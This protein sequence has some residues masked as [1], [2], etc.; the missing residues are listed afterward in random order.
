MTES[1]PSAARDQT[2]LRRVNELSVLAV[3]R[4]GES[5]PLREVA[6]ATGLS[7]RTT[8][9]VA[10]A[11]EAHGWLASTETD[12][13]NRRSVGRPARHYRFRPGV[14]HVVGIDVGTRRVQ[15]QVADLA[16][17]TV[18][19]SHEAVSPRDSAT[20]RLAAAERAL[21][22]ALQSA[23]LDPADIW[24][25]VMGTSG[26]V[27]PDGTVTAST[28]LPGWSGLH[29][30]ERLGAVL[31][32]R[33]EVAN[34]SNLAAL[35]ERWL[36]HRA[37]TMLYLM[38]G[39]RLGAGLVI[40]GQL[41][42]GSTG[43]AGEIGALRGVGWHD[44]ADRLI[45]HGDGD[46]AADPATAA[47]QVFQKARNGD[48]AAL[49]AVDRFVADIA[50]GA[51][52]MVLTLDPDLVVLGGGFAGAADLLLPRLADELARSCLHP[53]R[54]QASGLGDDAVIRG[55]LRLALD[56]VEQRITSLDS[57]VPLTPAAI[58]PN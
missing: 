58:R 27:G 43:A 21:R 51:T 16:A 12:I 7:W 41:H 47:D 52:A 17:T 15:V 8:Q 57:A 6:E 48:P 10:E 42:R 36:G 14:G 9:V 45:A 22:A 24:A 55:A 25:A 33:I 46:P 23:G 31:P 11:L 35:A 29:P 32:C 19:D 34:D 37:P 2:S 44:A 20:T 49:G 50:H 26:V 30:A 1:F 53:P 3:L 54:L 5:Q 40:G 13:G 38:T 28:L 39:V 18:A 56:A 4:A